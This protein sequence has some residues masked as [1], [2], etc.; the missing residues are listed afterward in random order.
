M[1]L[2]SKVKI[3]EVGPRDGLQNEKAFI[4]TAV[5]IAFVDRLTDAGFP[6]S[7]RVVRIA[8]MGAADGR[9]GRG[10]GRHPAQARHPLFGPHAQYER[11]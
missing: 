4:D 5:K 1:P 9:R 8:Q 2:P 11:L 3:V 7:R 10:D 6:I